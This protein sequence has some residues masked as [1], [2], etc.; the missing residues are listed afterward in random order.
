MKGSTSSDYGR[1]RVVVVVLGS[2]LC[3]GRRESRGGIVVR[4]LDVDSS[5]SL[6][7]PYVIN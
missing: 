5:P 2:S 4:P 6:V 7:I 3:Q 1:C